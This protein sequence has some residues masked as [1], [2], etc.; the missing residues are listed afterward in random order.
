MMTTTIDDDVMM[1]MTTTI[2]N[3]VMIMTTMTINVDVINDGDYDDD[4]DDND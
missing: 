3:D 4:H 2:D 1:M